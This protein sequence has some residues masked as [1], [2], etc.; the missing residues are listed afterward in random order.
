MENIPDLELTT[1][2][3]GYQMYVVRDDHIIS[4]S[5]LQTG[6]WEKETGDL[7]S[8][9]V[10]RGMNIIE[11]GCNQ[12]F[13]SINIAKRIGEEGKLWCVD[14]NPQMGAV[15]EKNLSLNGLTNTQYIHTGVSDQVGQ[16]EFHIGK[17]S[18]TGC[19]SFYNGLKYMDTDRTV[20]VNTTT[21][22]ALFHQETIHGIKMDIELSELH[23]LYGAEN[24][25]SR[26][27]PF[28]I[29]EWNCHNIC[30]DR[31][32]CEEMDSQLFNY[33]QDFD[34]KI[35]RLMVNGS[36]KRILTPHDL[37]HTVGTTLPDLFIH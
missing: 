14:A 15:L 12:G 35:D 20:L 36:R 34:Y 8:N 9:Y 33:L 21:L 16:S 22:D 19:S 18:N 28:L 24:I 13:H 26:N 7:I 31:Q 29:I 10:N 25:L 3:L 5:I 6:L 11:V 32:L 37:V 30:P 17:S 27:K 2:A 1:T 4:K 23:A